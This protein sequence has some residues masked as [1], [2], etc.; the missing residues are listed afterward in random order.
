MRVEGI[1]QKVDEFLEER[2]RSANSDLSKGQVEERTYLE[3][4]S[5]VGELGDT[6]LSTS[7]TSFFGAVHDVLNQPE[8][9]SVRNLAV[10]QGE[11]LS[12][13]ISR[14][15][16]L[17][18]ELRKDVNFR[19]IAVA[20]E[21]NSLLEEI[22]RLNTQIVAQE[23]GGVRNSDAVGLRDSRQ[24]AL[25]RLSQL[26]DV[27]S[28]EQESG[29]ITVFSGGEFLVFAGEYREVTTAL[30]ADK[31][32]SI[33]EI[34]LAETDAVIK[35]TS[36]EVAGLINAR[37][38]ILGG[39]IDD[40]SEFS[41][42]LAFEFNKVY[43]GGQGLRGYS[44]LTSEHFVDDIT[45]SLDQAGLPFTPTNGSFQ[46]HVFNKQTGLFETTDIVVDLNGLDEDVSLEGLAE[47]LDN[48][49]GVA[50]EI[51]PS[52]GLQL[53]AE[54]A[55]LEFAFAKDT[56]GVLASLG[57]NTFFSGTSASDLRI[58]SA[59]RSDPSTFAASGGG[60]G[61]D[62]DNALTLADLFDAP[63]ES[64]NGQS[65]AVL[66]DRFTSETVQASSVA[67]SVAEG[68]RVFQKTLEGEQLGISGVSIDEEA[69]RMISY[70]RTFQ[71]SARYIATISE[72]LD[73]LVNL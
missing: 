65:L 46:V 1:V 31:G 23:G 68:F 71:A 59:V 37:D 3:L 32:L 10:L 14:L 15:D 48:V 22:A 40:L 45:A 17:V 57:L 39:F 73:V 19:V 6:D 51:T 42:T 18:R 36:G 16:G 21:V 58:N 70:Q 53:T 64:A 13:G 7:L 26:I 66:Y 9:L 25:G 61:N 38:E 69:V 4:E 35:S 2:L 41:Q 55:N 60:I 43:S 33:A 34:R 24:A 28:I 8:S 63:L 12:T 20:G 49:D 72:L 67:R 44:E 62:I 54:S 11:T 30:S 47:L 5:L 52:R 50:A 27:R 56:S 29:S